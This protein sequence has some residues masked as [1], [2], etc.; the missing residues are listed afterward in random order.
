MEN[1]N[2]DDYIDDRITIYSTDDPEFGGYGRVSHET[3]YATEILP[4][5]RGGFMAYLP[6]RTA[7]VFRKK[8][9]E[10]A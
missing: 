10:K 2:I 7:S 8:G 5:G 6:S 9:S 1:F 3:D 4:D